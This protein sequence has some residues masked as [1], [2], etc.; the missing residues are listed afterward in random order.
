MPVGAGTPGEEPGS[1]GDAPTAVPQMLQKFVVAL[2]VAPQVPQSLRPGSVA[3][4][5]GEAQTTGVP[6]KPQNFSVSATGLLQVAQ[7][8]SATGSGTETVG[9]TDIATGITAGTGPSLTVA[10]HIL[11]NFSPGCTEFPQDRQDRTA[12]ACT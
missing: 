2:M 5:V 7:T 1:A 4:A 8:G 11:Q 6:Q 12:S 3:G 10:P 9:G